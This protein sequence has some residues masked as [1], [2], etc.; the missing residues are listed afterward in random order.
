MSNTILKKCLDELAKDKP[1]LDYVLGML[2]SLYEV[3]GESANSRQIPSAVPNFAPAPA[4][5]TM[6]AGVLQH[7]ADA[8]NS[9]DEVTF[10]EARTRAALGTVKTMSDQL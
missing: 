6:N 2:E 10:L 7:F 3:L 1:R 8:H 5:M 9:N 4:Q